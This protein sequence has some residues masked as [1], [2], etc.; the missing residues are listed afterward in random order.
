MDFCRLKN[1]KNQAL[2]ENIKTDGK[3]FYKKTF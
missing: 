1:I 2:R 3:V